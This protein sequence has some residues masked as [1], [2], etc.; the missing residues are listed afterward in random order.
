MRG[1]FPIK[2]W[3]KEC[4]RDVTSL[5]GFTL[6][7]FIIFLFIGLTEW[8]L[9][10]KLIFSFF[11]TM[12]IAYVIRIIYFKERPLREFYATHVERME[13]S[14][15]PSL[16]TMRFSALA[17]VLVPY[18]D[19]FLAG[20][21]LGIFVVVVGLSRMNLKKHYLI[22]VVVGLLLG[23]MVGVFAVKFI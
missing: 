22:D 14:S 23:V 9:V 6:Y 15:F 8:S 5:G 21:F 4:V 19:N 12:G 10:G 18:F 16:H 11:V 7:W 17:T 20:V 2:K 1:A 13:A 3:S